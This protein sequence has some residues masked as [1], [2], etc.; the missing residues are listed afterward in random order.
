[1]NPQVI[2]DALPEILTQLL[3]FLIV[4]WVLKTFAFKSILAVVDARR[5]KIEDEFAGIESKKHDLESL[6]KEYRLKI[7]KIEDEARLKI[8]EAANVGLALA[9]DLQD[10]ARQDAQKMVDRAKEEIVQDLTKAKIS[11]RGE[12]V[13]LSALISEKII[14]EKLNTVEHGRLVDQFLKELQKV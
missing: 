6:E 3:G 13:E 7:E 9:R 14:H 11:M 8:Q 4:F 10:K 5:K 12:L 2:K 1:M